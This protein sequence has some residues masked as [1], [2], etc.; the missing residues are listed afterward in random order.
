MRIPR[1]L[2]A[3]IAR[4]VRSVVAETSGRGACDTCG[5][6]AGWRSAMGE[7]PRCYMVAVWEVPTMVDPPYGVNAWHHPRLTRAC[8]DWGCRVTGRSLRAADRR[9]SS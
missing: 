1:E 9:A 7:C 6:V 2:R 4:V 5:R 8:M 3:D